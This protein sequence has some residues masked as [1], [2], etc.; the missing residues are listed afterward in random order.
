M[1]ITD[2]NTDFNMTAFNLNEGDDEDDE[3]DEYDSQFY[4]IEHRLTQVIIRG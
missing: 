1:S 2:R 4:R 3:Y